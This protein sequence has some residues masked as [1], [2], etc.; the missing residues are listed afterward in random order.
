MKS[1]LEYDSRDA[2]Y[3]EIIDY[4]IMHSVRK[5]MRMNLKIKN[6]HYFF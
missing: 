6:V 4:Y 2:R 1:L 5:T 3:Q